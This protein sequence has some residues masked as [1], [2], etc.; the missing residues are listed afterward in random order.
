MRSYDTFSTDFREIPAE[1]ELLAWL[2]YI[3]L[4]NTLDGKS[5]NIL[6]CVPNAIRTQTEV[7]STQNIARY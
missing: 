1:V 2:I 7:Q 4:P 6:I 5:I 3:N